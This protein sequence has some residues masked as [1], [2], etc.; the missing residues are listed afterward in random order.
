MSLVVSLAV[1]AGANPAAVAPPQHHTAAR[2]VLP[3]EDDIHAHD[4]VHRWGASGQS[5]VMLFSILE[6]RDL[7]STVKLVH[8]RQGSTR[9]TFTLHVSRQNSSQATG[10]VGDG[11][12]MGS[13]VQK[14]NQIRLP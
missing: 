4:L 7:V 9:Y 5:R 3:Q 12:H 2:G 10:M 8:Q 14:S 6:L 13:P 11:E 1:G